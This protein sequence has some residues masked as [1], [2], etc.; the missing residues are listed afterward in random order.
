MPVEL[1][2]KPDGTLKSKYWYGSY[3]LKG[4]R[5]VTRLGVPVKGAV[6]ASLREKSDEDFETSRKAAKDALEAIVADARAKRHPEEYVQKLHEIRTGRRIGSVPLGELAVAWDKAPR[7]RKGSPRYVKQAHSHFARF[8]TFIEAKY[9]GTDTL[10][11]VTPD[12]AEAF[13]EGERERGV[14]GRTCNAVLILMRSAFKALGNRA[15]I[16]RNPFEG[17]PTVSEDTTHRRPF[18]SAEIEAILRA[19]QDD[20]FIRPIILTGIYTA[21]RRGDCCTLRWGDVDLKDGFVRVKTSKT[22]ETVEIP[23][24]PPLRAELTAHRQALGKAYPAPDVYVFPEQAKMYRGNADGITRRVRKVLEKAGFFDKPE[25]EEENAAP[26][27]D[28]EEVAP[29]ELQRCV[30]EMFATLTNE[31]VPTEKRQHMEEAFRR[32]SDGQTLPAI[33]TA[34]GMSKSSI[35]LYLHEI[36]RRTGLRVL[37]QR[38]Q[39]HKEKKQRG[40]VSVQREGGARRVSVRDF[41]SFRVTWITLALSAGV[42]LELVQRVTGHKTTQVVLKHYFK[43]G[44]DAF[45][46]ALESA[47]PA[48]MVAPGEAGKRKAIPTTVVSEETEPYTTQAGPADLLEKALVELAAVKSKSKHLIAAVDLVTEAKN[49]IDSRVIREVGAARV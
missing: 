43:P 16:V 14:S 42:P 41:H 3:M 39:A 22:G 49:W 40:A 27:I 35:S 48:L 31:D 32:Y 34:M 25:D 7:K 19:A 4:K 24:F 38:R 33:A 18:N 23:I 45:K 46:A 5:H 1:R 37:R 47:M 21:M 30:P 26:E 13:M 28:L 12:M 10:A 29:E 17:I 15:N 6:P 2:R 11:D 8:V 44:R 36:E 9:P 20:D